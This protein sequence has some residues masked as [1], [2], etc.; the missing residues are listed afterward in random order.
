MPALLPVPEPDCY[1]LLG[2][3]PA[4][5]QEEITA[6]LW[7][8][9]REVHPDLHPSPENRAAFDLLLKARVTLTDPEKRQRYHIQQAFAPLHNRYCLHQSKL[10]I[11]QRHV[12]YW[13]GEVYLLDGSGVFDRTA[14]KLRAYQDWP[15]LGNY[16]DPS[17]SWEMLRDVLTDSLHARSGLVVLVWTEA[18]NMLLRGLDDLLTAHTVLR[19]VVVSINQNQETLVN[20]H[21]LLIGTGHNFPKSLG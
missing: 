17:T 21:F 16:R 18:Q 9:L 11:V 7:E 14:F 15:N 2:L 1:V 6:C 19:D 20:A 12:Q 13:Q 3:L 5:T 10:S 4:A 8:R